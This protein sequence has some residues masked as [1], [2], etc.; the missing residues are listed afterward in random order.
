MAGRSRSVGSVASMLVALVVLSG[1]GDSSET[2][3]AESTSAVVFDLDDAL[4]ASDVD[5]DADVETFRQ[6][7]AA[8]GVDGDVE[9]DATSITVTVPADDADVVRQVM[10]VQGRVEFRPVLEDLGDAWVGDAGR[11]GDVPADAEVTLVDGDGYAMRLGPSLLTGSAIES[12]D[13]QDGGDGRPTVALVFRAGADGID[14]FNDAAALCYS[15]AAECPAI[16]EQPGRLAIVLD[17]EVLS[18]PT[19]NNPSFQRDAIQIS[20]D[21]S[22]EEVRSTAAALDSGGLGG[23]WVARI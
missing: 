18:A 1:C 4:S 14:L 2:P 3:S 13:A 16:A 6:R 12:A 9:A 8:L 23:R 20:G 5:V 22:T 15:G 17:G 10:A 11:N 19:I 7:L 21:F